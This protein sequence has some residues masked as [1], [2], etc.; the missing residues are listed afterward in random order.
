MVKVTDSCSGTK[1]AAGNQQKHLKL[2][3]TK[4]A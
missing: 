4:K 1:V 2:S 3:F